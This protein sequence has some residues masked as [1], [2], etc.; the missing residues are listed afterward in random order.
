MNMLKTIFG[1]ENKYILITGAGGLLGQKHAEAVASVGGIPILTDINSDIL[2]KVCDKVANQFNCKAI[3]LSMDVT[4]ESSVKKVC[5][6]L[7]DKDIHVDILINNAARNP[8]V[9]NQG[10]LNP[11]RLE[12]LDLSSWH[13]D[14]T[15]GLTGALICS[16]VFGAD[17][18]KRGKG[19]IINISSDLGV[20]APD[21]R[22][23]EKDNIKEDEQD[24]KPVSYSVVKHGLIGLTKYLS[25]YWAHK[26][27]RCNALSPGGV[28]NGQNEVFLNK[29]QDR[30]PMARMAHHDEYMG[31]IIFLASEASSYMNGANLIIDGGRSVW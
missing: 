21:Q 18:A 29:I 3:S 13:L 11:N 9:G 4:S 7:L 17:M 22:L 15:V 30:I 27:V 19:N 26:N 28:F 20:I 8:A 14:L 10:L 23:Y 6:E 12:S 5:N 16:K 31:A 25:T 24:V 2:K 1:L